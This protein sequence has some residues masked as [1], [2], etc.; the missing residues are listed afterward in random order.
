MGLET[1][2]KYV[3]RFDD[4]V[5]AAMLNHFNMVCNKEHWKDEIDAV[6]KDADMYD[7][8]FMGLAI[9]HF[10]GSVPDFWY[11]SETETRVTAPGYWEAVG[12]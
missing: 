12:S 6:V 3:E 4:H 8:D 9:I 5:Y 10:T 11:E 2:V 1:T 7:L